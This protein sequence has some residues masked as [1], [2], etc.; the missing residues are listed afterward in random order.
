MSLTAPIVLS[1]IAAAVLAW[2]LART[3][4]AM[5]EGLL[6]PAI[7]NASGGTRWRRK[8]VRMGKSVLRVSTLVS[9]MVEIV[10]VAILF[11]VLILVMRRMVGRRTESG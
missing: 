7:D 9:A 4:S 2:G 8:R 1:Q 5:T 6:Y 3:Q 10:F 11:A